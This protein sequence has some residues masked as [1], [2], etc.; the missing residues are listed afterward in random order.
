MKAVA[1]HL[2]EHDVARIKRAA[3]L[4]AALRE[5]YAEVLAEPCP[6]SMLDLLDELRA[7]ESKQTKRKD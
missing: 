5:A 4:G 3:K 2:S 7:Q 1:K 6:Q